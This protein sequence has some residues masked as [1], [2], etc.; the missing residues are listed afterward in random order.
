MEKTTEKT[1]YEKIMFM[2]K[3][4]SD[5]KD[6]GHTCVILLKTLPPQISYCGNDIC[7]GKNT[8]DE[9][10]KIFTVNDIDWNK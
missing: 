9:P 7:M 2:Q 1:F 5:L 8:S 3:M 4:Y 10:Y 6:Q